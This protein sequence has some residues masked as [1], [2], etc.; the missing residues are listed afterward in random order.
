M[1]SLKENSLFSEGVILLLDEMYLQQEVQYDGRK[2]IECDSELQ[3]YKSIICFM[4]VSLKQSTPY[5]LKATPL[6]K[7]NHHIVLDGQFSNWLSEWREAG[8]LC[9][10][11]QTFEAL[12]NSNRGIADLSSDLLNEGYI[13]LSVDKCLD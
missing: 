1:P 13:N 6:T 12:I 2:L 10:S 4:V 3:M 9:L 5:I 11:K 8:I 7:I